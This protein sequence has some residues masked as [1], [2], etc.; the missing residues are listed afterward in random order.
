MNAPAEERPEGIVLSGFLETKDAVIGKI[1]DP[2]CKA[3][4]Q[5]MAECEDVVGVTRGVRVMLLNLEI[6]LMIEQTIE[7]VGGV[8][9][10]GADGPGMV[11]R[12]AIRDVSVEHRHRIPAIFGVHLSDDGFAEGGR[13]RLPIEEDVRPLPHR[14]ARGISPCSLIIAAKA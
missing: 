4:A 10:C 11:R 14:E 5:Q 6:A 12:V 3:V 7:N 1:P 13:K 9:H 2:G 8:A